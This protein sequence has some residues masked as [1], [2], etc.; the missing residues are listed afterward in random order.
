MPKLRLRWLFRLFSLMM[1]VIAGLILIGAYQLNKPLLI[2][3][4]S[5]VDLKPGG[6]LSGLL[7]ELEAQGVMPYPEYLLAYSRL[8][9]KARQVQAGSYVLEVGLT[10]LM[11]LEKLTAGDVLL[12]QITLVEGWRLSDVE[13]Y[14]AEQALTPSPPYAQLPWFQQWLQEMGASNYEGLFFP[15]TYHFA[16]G[17][18]QIELLK[19]S[20]QR[21]QQVLLEEWANRADNLPY[22]T[23]YEAL[24]MASLIEKETGVASERA[25]IAGVFVRRLQRG[26]RLQTDPSVIYG[27]GSEFDGNLKSRHLKDRSNRYNT[28]RHHG[29][30][31]TPIALV[32]REAIRAALN[33][34]PGESLY[35]VAKGDG[36]H[37]FSTNFEEHQRAVRKYQI[38]QRKK[39][40]QSSP[41]H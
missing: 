10:P 18:L 23:P 3:S 36:S 38:F 19:K 11:L 9:G 8:T 5:S 27:L 33:P 29:L 24:I 7:R 30:P 17:S 34:L 22:K 1:A 40:Y 21:L 2:A 32:G 35:F 12:Q 41:S 15:D 31:P 26:M 13:L 37:Y 25:E 14:L 20:A 4:A 28:Y 6:S 39:N 16:A